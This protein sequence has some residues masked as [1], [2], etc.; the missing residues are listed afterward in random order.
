MGIPGN[1]AV[2]PAHR[3]DSVEPGH[4]EVHQHAVGAMFLNEL[5]RLQTVRCFSDDVHIGNG[6]QQ[7]THPRSHEGVIVCQHYAHHTTASTGN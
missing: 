4:C 5:Q 1:C 3:L 2:G 6:F 7:Q